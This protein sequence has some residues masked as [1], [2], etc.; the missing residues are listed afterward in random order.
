MFSRL[1]RAHAALTRELSARLVT[2]HG[3]SVNDYEALLHLSREDG[4]MRRVDLAE[5]LVLTPSGVTRLLDGLERDGWVRKGECESDA[6]VT[7]A[8]LTDEGRELLERAGRTH[9]T[10]I[11]EIF[12]ERFAPEELEQLVDLLGRLPGATGHGESCSPG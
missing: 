3:L 8:V 12:E 4:G 9:V 6:R 1:L 11:R 5:R 10:Q 2:D 7:Y